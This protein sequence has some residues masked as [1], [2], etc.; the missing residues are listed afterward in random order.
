MKGQTAQLCRLNPQ[1][2]ERLRR[3]I[4]LLINKLP[5]YLI[6]RQN[7]PPKCSIQ[8]TS[9]RFQNRLRQINVSTMLD[10]FLV[11]ELG[12]LGCGVVLWAVELVG[13]R[14][15]GV[16]LEHF[17]EGF[18]YVDC[19]YYVRGRWDGYGERELRERANS[20]LACG[21]R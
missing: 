6:G 2:F 15:G 4:N 19:L 3:R 5:L 12:N 21:L 17:F 8:K 14:G 7:R 18:A 20:V 16:V 9:Y 10:D 1:I 11:D 13:L